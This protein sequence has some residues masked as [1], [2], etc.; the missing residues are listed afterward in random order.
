MCC[1]LYPFICWIIIKEGPDNF[2][3]GRSPHW[4]NH[5]YMFLYCIVYLMCFISTYF[6]FILLI[7]DLVFL[8]NYWKPCISDNIKARHYARSRISC[9]VLSCTRR[10]SCARNRISC[11]VSSY[12]K[13]NSCA[14][15]EKNI[16]ISKGHLGFRLVVLKR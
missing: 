8:T 15:I 12:I 13:I 10:K 16:Q 5:I 14:R 6:Y 2:S 11:M 4:V 1:R 7:H 9:T 3:S